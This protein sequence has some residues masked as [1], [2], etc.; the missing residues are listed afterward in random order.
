MDLKQISSASVGR[1]LELGERYRLLNEPE[2]AASI[3]RDILVV[4]PS[5]QEARRMLLLALTDLFGRRQGASLPE[6]EALAAELQSEYDREYYRGIVYE[7][8]GRCK[9]QEGVPGHV[10]A[11]WL[12]RAMQRYEAAEQVR[13]TDDDSA[14]LRWN[15]CQRLLDRLPDQAREDEGLFGD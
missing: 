7:R 6:A 10:V 12:Q 8:W 5:N 2:L 9:L 15:T 14:L 3:C 13:P 4:D 11:E 1:A